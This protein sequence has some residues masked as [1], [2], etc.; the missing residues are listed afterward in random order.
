MSTDKERAAKEVAQFQ[1]M[2]FMELLNLY[3]TTVEEGEQEYPGYVSGYTNKAYYIDVAAMEAELDRKVA[4]KNQS[5]RKPPPAERK[6]PTVPSGLSNI[7]ETYTVKIVRPE[8][9]SLKFMQ[10]YIRD[11][12]ED[13]SGQMDP[14]KPEFQIGKIG[15]VTVRRNKA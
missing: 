9:V 10:W 5:N 2:S 8:G 3:H 12:L 6:P 14:D 1:E 15:K 11:A 13:W 7:Q 4:C